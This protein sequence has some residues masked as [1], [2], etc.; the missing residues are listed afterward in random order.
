MTATMMPGSWWTSFVGARPHSSWTV[1]SAGWR[2]RLLRPG[3][4][5]EESWLG[6]GRTEEVDM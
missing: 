3:V 2:N 1:G 6:T 5:C 4:A